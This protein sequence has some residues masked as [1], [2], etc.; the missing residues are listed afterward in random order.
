VPL[1]RRIGY[2]VVLNSDEE[3]GSLGSAAL[4]ASAARASAP[5]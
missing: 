5:P 3:V 4:I 1:G 2:E